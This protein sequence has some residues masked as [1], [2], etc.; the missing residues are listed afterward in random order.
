MSAV[1]LPVSR[2][3]VLILAVL[4][5]WKQLQLS[6]G[7]QQRGGNDV[8]KTEAKTGNGHDVIDAHDERHGHSVTNVTPVDAD[9]VVE[10]TGLTLT[11]AQ[12]VHL[13]CGVMTSSSPNTMHSVKP[14]SM[15]SSVV[16]SSP[17]IASLCVTSPGV[18]PASA[19]TSTTNTTSPA[20]T[21]SRRCHVIVTDATASRLR[22]NA[23]FLR[24]AVEGGHVIYG[25]NTGYGGSADVRS[26]REGEVQLALVTHL[27]AG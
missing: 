3:T 14:S 16:T 7:Q 25:V 23:A 1:S 17:T 15:S 18:S 8:I 22:E 19:V 24:A 2:H 13:S 6:S 20:V 4:E 12:L 26:S 9:D 21:S 5:E 27:N 10:T 11:V